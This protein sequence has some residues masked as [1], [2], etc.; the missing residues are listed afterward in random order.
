MVDVGEEIMCERVCQALRNCGRHECG[1][2][3]CPLSYQAKNRKKRNLTDALRPTTSDDLHTC[4][5]VCGRLLSCGL[6]TCPK[7][8]HR[9]ACGRCLQASYDELICHCGRT[10]V[11]PPV[12]CGTTISCPYPCARDPPPCGHP[13][14]P[15]PC[16]ESPECPPCPYLTVRPCACGKD[17]AVKNVR[18]SQD[19]DR[20]SCG[21]TC[22]ALLACG[23]H[24]CERSCHRHEPATGDP[25]LGSGECHQT[26]NKPKR[27]CKHPCTSA[28]H[29]PR[30]CPENDP[31]QAIVTQ[32]CPCGNIQQRASCGASSANPTSRQGI[33]LKCNS[34]CQVKQRNARL[35]D[36]LG[37]KD[38]DGPGGAKF[39]WPVEL[40]Q[41]A[42]DNHPFVL[43]V[44]KTLRDF[45]HGPK[46]AQ[47]LPSMPPAKRA[48]VMGVADQYRLTRELIDA[49]PNRSVQIRRRVDTRIPPVLLSAVS[50]PAPKPVLGNLRST[51]AVPKPWGAVPPKS[52]TTPSGSGTTTP[53]TA[54]AVGA[55]TLNAPSIGARMASAVNFP[56]TGTAAGVKSSRPATPVAPVLPESGRS[57]GVDGGAADWEASDGE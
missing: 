20:V 40:R 2:L 48:F 39:E 7:P 30:K 15:H 14:T 43:T 22:G 53:N 34:E 38:R 12:A 27:I 23:Y 19:P 56:G 9:G 46:Q 4:E 6:H 36:A 55:G 51:A 50:A 32:T 26:C 52:S 29:A 13:K 5:L 35:A 31:C 44:E 33:G 3:C 11:Y 24:R 16:H 42:R 18:C 45:F 49:E 21:Q 57:V 54:T 37:I 1:R 47:I 10:I 25:A 17:P 41:F 28:C 8:D